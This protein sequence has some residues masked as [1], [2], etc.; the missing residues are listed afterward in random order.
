[1]D[2]LETTLEGM[3]PPTVILDPVGAGSGIF[4][5]LCVFVFVFRFFR[6]E[7][8]YIGGAGIGKP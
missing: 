8:I 5:F 2:G 1:M 3:H 4:L 7:F 6:K